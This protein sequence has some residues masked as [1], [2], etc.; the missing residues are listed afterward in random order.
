MSIEYKQLPFTAEEVES[1]LTKAK[2]G[3]SSPEVWDETTKQA[4]RAALAIGA[5]NDFLQLPKDW[6]DDTKEQIKSA[7]QIET[8]EDMISTD[9]FTEA[10]DDQIKDAGLLSA[11]AANWDASTK[12]AVRESIGIVFNADGSIVING[13]TI[14]PL[15][16]T[17]F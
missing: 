17:K 11:T 4:V 16:T 2:N 15:G 14:E 3:L 10:V 7:L 5:D 9:D 1:I 12:K 6:D 8:V 13:M